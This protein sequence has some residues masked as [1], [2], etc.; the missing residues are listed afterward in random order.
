MKFYQYRNS[1]LVEIEPYPISLSDKNREAD[2]SKV[3]I[4]EDNVEFEYIDKMWMA[5]TPCVYSKQ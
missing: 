1:E 4:R 2:T 5:I 3:I